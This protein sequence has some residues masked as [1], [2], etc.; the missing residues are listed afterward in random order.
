MNFP[1]QPPHPIPGSLSP[2][3][4]CLYEHYGY[5]PPCC[6]TNSMLCTLLCVQYFHLELHLGDWSITVHID[7]DANEDANNIA[8]TLGQALF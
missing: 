5:M 1:G 4:P 3:N 7:D 8:P 6:D 2:G